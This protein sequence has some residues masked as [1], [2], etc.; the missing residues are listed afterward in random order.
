[1]N[2]VDSGADYYVTG[3]ALSQFVLG[4]ERLGLPTRQL[5]RSCGLDEHVHLQPM[6]KVPLYSYER[7]LL[8]LILLSGD[9]MLG[10]HIGQQ[11][12]PSA[13]GVIAV[14]GMGGA[15]LRQSIET[16]ARYQSL[17]SG[18]VGDL[19]LEDH[20][21]ALR[22]TIRAM[23]QNPVLRRHI[24]ECVLVLMARMYRFVTGYP[25]LA[26]RQ[27]WLE[28]TP[29]S[30]EAAAMVAR[31]ANCP[32]YFGATTTGL[33]LAPETLS[34]TLNE[35]GDES[36]RMAE[37][38][39]RQQLEQQQSGGDISQIRLQVHD[40]MMTSAPRRELVADRLN[41]SVRTLDRR[42][43]EAGLTWQSLLD[44]LRLQL[45]REYLANPGMTIREVAG[46][47]GFADIRAFQRRFRVW[48]G[49]TPTEYRQQRG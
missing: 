28:Y 4:G 30:E 3:I 44:S 43:A 42:L 41:I 23:H 45:A 33:E 49:T 24:F 46:K 38:L 5:L 34:L 12:M 35:F 14:M 22:V 16:T 48:T 19:S 40:L 13:Y 18:T 37:N 32:V 2:E 31:E 7:F 21:G 10:F 36:M 8:E 26:P 6:A 1:M 9:E 27:V 29:P 25:D 11:V 47:L 17:V 15:T 20:D 39:A